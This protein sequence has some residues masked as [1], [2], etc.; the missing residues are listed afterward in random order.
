MEKIDK[1]VATLGLKI[2]EGAK[3]VKG[4]A[5][6][7]EILSNWLPLDRLLLDRIVSELP[8]PIEAQNFR[9]PYLLQLN[10]R[11]EKI[12]PVIMNALSTCDHS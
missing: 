3:K 6:I 10:L 4:H 5:L 8:D 2:S 7:R 12:D 1:I 11:K 9:L